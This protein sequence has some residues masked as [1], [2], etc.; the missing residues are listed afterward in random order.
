[1]TD[2]YPGY[3]FHNCNIYF[4][5]KKKK[6]A[7]VLESKWSEPILLSRSGMRCFV[8]LLLCVHVAWSVRFH[9]SV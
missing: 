7:C 8:L 9:V 5:Y 1:M 3:T 2:I 6:N 4:S